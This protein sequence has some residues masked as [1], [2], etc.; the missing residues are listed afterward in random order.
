M[1]SWSPDVPSL[2]RIL[3]T[4]WPD[5]VPQSRSF[6]SSSGTALNGSLSSVAFQHLGPSA[7]DPPPQATPTQVSN[8]SSGF[9][10][11]SSPPCPLYTP[12]TALLCFFPPAAPPA[13][14]RPLSF[15][16]CVCHT[17]FSKPDQTPSL[18]SYSLR[19]LNSYSSLK[20]PVMLSSCPQLAGNV[21]RAR[22][23]SVTWHI[24]PRE[25]V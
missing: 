5:H 19:A 9:Q 10:L 21:P 13:Y 14:N 12:S 23:W 11:G 3:Q 17:N 6:L 7:R 20:K 24:T 16:A 8:L 4:T 18:E 2:L 25:S 22:S 1:Q 15:S